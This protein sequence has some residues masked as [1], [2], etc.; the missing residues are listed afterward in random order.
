MDGRAG[1][2]G[3]REAE[4]DRFI[5]VKM[6]PKVGDLLRRVAQQRVIYALLF[7]F[8][9][10]VPCGQSFSNETRSLEEQANSPFTATRESAI[11]EL[12]RGK[13][14]RAFE[15]LR[16]ILLNSPDDS[17]RIMAVDAL[18]ILKDQRSRGVLERIAVSEPNYSVRSRAI[19]HITSVIGD[20]EQVRAF[21]RRILRVEGKGADDV[22]ARLCAAEELGKL[23]DGEGYDYAVRSLGNNDCSGGSQH[24]RSAAIRALVAIGRPDAIPT[25]MDLNRCGPD[26]TREAAEGIVRLRLRSMRSDHE[27]IAFLRETLADNPAYQ[28]RDRAAYELVRMH[29]WESLMV[30]FE[31]IRD[32]H[33]PGHDVAFEQVRYWAPGLSAIIAYAPDGLIVVLAA[34]IWGVPIMLGGGAL[35]VGLVF[36]VQSR[37]TGTVVGLVVAIALLALVESAARAGL[38]P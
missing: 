38:F 18:A 28:A 14:P 9:L 1:A 17:T 3:Q 25:L 36:I 4:S 15:I 30:L 6:P 5:I 8:F 32:R 24:I 16:D 34:M 7:V 21:Q 31:A 19:M 2:S 11:K 10:F 33:H 29:T 26:A 37:R 23:D 35:V 27:R 20:K 13:E 12:G 22:V